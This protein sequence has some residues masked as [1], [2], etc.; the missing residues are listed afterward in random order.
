LSKYKNIIN[1][2]ELRNNKSRFLNSKLFFKTAFDGFINFENLFN[3]SK[4]ISKSD[5][6]NG[7]TNEALNNKFKIILKPTKRW[8]VLLSSDYFLPNSK[9]KSQNYLFLGAAI[10]YRPKN[11]KFEFNF[12]AN[13]ILNENKFEQIQIS[14]F[15]TSIFRT[16]ILPRYYLLN[17]SYSF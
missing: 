10:R 3:F 14:D 2:S 13:N 9:E 17:I 7:F 16:S 15:S 5:D 1:N 6:N 12:R 11:K 4:A 8:L